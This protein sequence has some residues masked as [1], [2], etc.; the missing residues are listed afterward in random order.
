MCL[1]REYI[2]SQDNAAK[3]CLLIMENA[4]HLLRF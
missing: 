3:E 1:E 4:V 2:G